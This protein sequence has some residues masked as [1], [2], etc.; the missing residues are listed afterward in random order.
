MKGLGFSGLG[1]HSAHIP[2][3]A[4]RDGYLSCSR[5]VYPASRVIAASKSGIFTLWM[6]THD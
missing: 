2:V 6:A 5:G 4:A 3:C 1:F